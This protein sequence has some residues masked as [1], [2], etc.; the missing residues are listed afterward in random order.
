MKYDV[1]K[2]FVD[3]LEVSHEHDGTDHRLKEMVESNK[4]SRRMEKE[5]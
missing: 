1:V 2:L 5:E 3:D 4:W